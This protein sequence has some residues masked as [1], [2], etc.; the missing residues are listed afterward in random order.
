M[1]I[2]QSVSTEIFLIVA[3]AKVVIRLLF[4]C[5]LGGIVRCFASHRLKIASRR[6]ISEIMKKPIAS[7]CGHQPMD[8]GPQILSLRS[9]Q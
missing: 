7:P 6:K 2:P 3:L 4:K 8:I 5:Y 9:S 1:G